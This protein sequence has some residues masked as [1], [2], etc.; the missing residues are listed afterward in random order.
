MRY[1]QWTAALVLLAAIPSVALS[2]EYKEDEEEE[3]HFTSPTYRY[4]FASPEDQRVSAHMRRDLKYVD[5][6]TEH[7]RGALRMSEAYL[8]DSRGT[9]PF[10]QRM[11]NAIIHNQKF[12]I[13]WLEDL[14]GRV[15][16]GPEKVVQIGD[17]H[18]VRL[19]AGITGMEHRQRF[20]SAPILS[21]TSTIAASK[22]ISEYDVIFAKSMKMHHEMA[23]AMAHEYNND[24]DG[25]N[26]VIKE[27]NRGIL[28]DQAVEIGIL[29]DFISEY[30]GDPDAVEI[31]PELH[32]M[33]GMPMNHMDMPHKN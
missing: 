8:Q 10:L 1:L 2:S 29:S 4:F 3:G 12:E 16:E 19:P 6:M 21:A 26:V 9:N 15:A 11:A 14:R 25:G 7:H 20:Q 13:G 33:M 32:E 28:R 23:L 22:P 27:I 5:E 30:A 24:P 17:L 18:L 31:P